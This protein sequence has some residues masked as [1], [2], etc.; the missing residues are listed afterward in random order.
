MQKLIILHTNDIHGRVDGLARLATL[1]EQIRAENPATPVLYLDAG[2]SEET[3]GRLSNLTRG[4]AMH[5]LLSVAGCAAA[6]VG[7]GGLPRYSPHVLKEYAAV[8]HYPHLLANIRNP[9]GSLLEGTQATA[10]LDA[11]SCKLGVIGLTAVVLGDEPVYESTFGLMSL[12]ALPLVQELA[13]DLRR[14]GADIVLLLS[15]LGL[16][17]DLL[18][19]PKIKDVVPVIIGAHSHHLVP[20]GIWSGNV[21]ITQ[22]GEYAQHLGRIDLNWTGERLQVERVTVIP[23]PED[24]A[25]LPRMQVAI[26]A[27]ETDIDRLLG[28]VIGELV[29]PLDYAADRECGMANLLADALRERTGAEV[30][31]VAA[32]AAFTGPLPAGPLKR[33]TLWDVCPSPGNPGI[34]E[35]TGAQLLQTITKGLDPLLAA[36][37]SHALRGRQRGLMHISGASIRSGQLSIGADLLEPA[38]IYMV[39]GSGW[40]LGPFGGYADPAWKLKPV[41]E[42]QVI[43]RDVLDAYFKGKGPVSVEMGRSGLLQ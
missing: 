29:E 17:D 27:I 9:D 7:N 19:A 38:R 5:R 30:A 36:R 11:G 4:A 22:A 26:A 40:E 21:L 39:A 2:D 33:L 14:Q 43:M 35:M 23:V 41:Y 8:A 15:H 10:L 24:L 25:P 13:A 18:L 1:I 28:D 20:G 42:I 37:T 3:S 6:T 32:G 12:P 16:P 31:L 34:V